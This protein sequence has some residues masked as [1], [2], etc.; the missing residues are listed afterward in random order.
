MS[1]IPGFHDESLRGKLRGKRSIRLSRSYRA[2]YQ[3]LVSGDAEL[4]QVEEVTK[5]DY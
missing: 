2:I 3:L 5:H 1:R 4:V